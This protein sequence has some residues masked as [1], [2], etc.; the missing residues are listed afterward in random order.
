[1]LPPPGRS[2]DYATICVAVPRI[3][4]DPLAGFQP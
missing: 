1:L 3:M 4:Q 2:L